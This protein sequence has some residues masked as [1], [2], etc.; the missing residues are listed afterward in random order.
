MTEMTTEVSFGLSDLDRVPLLPQQQE[1]LQR[2]REAALGTP[3]WRAR[4]ETEA[5]DLYAN[6]AAKCS[7]EFVSELLYRLQ[8]EESKHMKIVRD[9]LARL[10]AGHG[11]S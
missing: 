6:L 4:K 3:V 2:L 7:V 11:V 1:G 8:N 9:M 10:E 5:R